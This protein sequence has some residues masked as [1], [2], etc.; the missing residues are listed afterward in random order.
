MARTLVPGFWK[1]TTTLGSVGVGVTPWYI[2]IVYFDLTSAAARDGLASGS[3]VLFYATY[4]VLSLA[5]NA[6][7]DSTQS[8]IE[9]RKKAFI[10]DGTTLN[11]AGPEVLVYN[12]ST[13]P[14]VQGSISIGDGPGGANQGFGNVGTFIQAGVTRSNE[15]WYTTSAFSSLQIDIFQ[16]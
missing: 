11:N 15:T 1:T 4:K 9:E 14:G 13:I 7:D 8:I 16:P 6:L 3:P 5:H 10:W 12:Y 2:G